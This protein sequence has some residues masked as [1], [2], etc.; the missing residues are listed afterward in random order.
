MTKIPGEGSRFRNIRSS[1][2]P[3]IMLDMFKCYSYHLHSKAD[4]LF[5][6]WLIQ[7]FQRNMKQFFTKSPVYPKDITCYAIFA[8]KCVLIE[9]NRMDA[10]ELLVTGKFTIKLQMESILWSSFTVVSGKWELCFH[11]HKLSNSFT[12]RKNSPAPLYLWYACSFSSLE[13]CSPL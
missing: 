5:H 7:D 9:L 12:V 2:I 3:M 1:Q 8:F 10:V 4:K 11:G 13:I 6:A